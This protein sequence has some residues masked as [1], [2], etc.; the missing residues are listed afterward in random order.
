MQPHTT[1]KE[2]VWTEQRSSCVI[3]GEKNLLH[4]EDRQKIVLL[5]HYL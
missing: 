3:D 1:K 4:N 2:G 5:N